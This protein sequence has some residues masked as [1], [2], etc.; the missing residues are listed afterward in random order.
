MI[1]TPLVSVGVVTWNSAQYLAGCLAALA[2]QHYP[3]VEVVFVD[4]ASS[5]ES[6]AIASA[7]FPAA[8]VIRNTENRGYCGGHNQA[9]R[10][11]HGL[12]YMPLNPDVVIDTDYIVKLVKE[13]EA[14]PEVGTAG[15]KL[16]RPPEG[17]TGVRF[18]STGL[19]LDRRRRQYLRGHGEIDHGQYDEHRDTFGVDGAAPLY[20]RAML[21]EISF[22]G[23]YFDETFASHKEDVDVAWRAQ[24]FGW[25]SRYVP[26]AIAYHP[27][28]FR[29]SRREPVPPTIRIHSVKNRYLLMLKNESAYSWW[30]DCLFI[31]FYDLQI[32]IYLLL[33][34]HDSLPAFALLFRAWR[35]A[36]QWR[37][38]IWSHA[39][40]DPKQLAM[41]FR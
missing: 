37:R 36:R 39:R 16:L 14:L 18:D 40:V 8:T 22:E 3:N 26:T 17:E 24:I 9:I 4:N 1:N 5:D 35:R 25:H 15:G 41:W 31:L 10:A 13:M 19:F 23:E 7:C 38:H 28:S 32:L 21:D 30:R 27:R 2:V 6:V 29:P 20:R 12:Y 11:S 34:E 33:F